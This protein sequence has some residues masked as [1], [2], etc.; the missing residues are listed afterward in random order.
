MK[1]TVKNG[2]RVVAVVRPRKATMPVASLGFKDEFG[3]PLSG[4]VWGPEFEITVVPDGPGWKEVGDSTYAQAHSG[5]EG[6][7]VIQQ[8]M[9]RHPNVTAARI[10]YDQYDSCSHC[11]RQWEELWNTSD[12]YECGQPD[13]LSVIGEPVCCVA[14]INEFRAGRGIAP[15]SP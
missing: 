8:G 3:Q 11:N 4:Q 12:V 13:G 14:A 15:L 1:E 9:L 6:C 2:W 10:E 5:E 7:K